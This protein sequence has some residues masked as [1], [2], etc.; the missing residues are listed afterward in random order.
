MKLAHY[1]VG[2]RF[3]LI[4]TDLARLFKEQLKLYFVTGLYSVFLVIKQTLLRRSY[5]FPYD[6]RRIADCA[7][8]F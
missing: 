2:F 6:Q 3:F 1:S 5:G 4:R 8:F 7:R